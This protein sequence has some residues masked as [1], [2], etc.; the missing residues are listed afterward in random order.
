MPEETV[1]PLKVGTEIPPVPAPPIV[2]PATTLDL[3]EGNLM[4][5][6][7]A[8]EMRTA[9]VGLEGEKQTLLSQVQTLTEAATKR[10]ADLATA[11]QG[12]ISAEASV[13]TAD[14]KTKEAEGKA[15]NFVAPA[16]YQ[17]LKTKLGTQDWNM[18][19][20]RTGRMATQ[21]GIAPDK[22]HGKSVA[23]LDGIEEGLKLS[24]GTIKQSPVLNKGGSGGPAVLDTSNRFNETI[25]KN[26]EVLRRIR[27]GDKTAGEMRR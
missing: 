4:T 7:Q 16:D 17:E 22:L 26:K 2:P 14:A 19:V 6:D 18:L 1:D 20:E 11:N 5:K 25:E 21:Y 15:A 24:G 27:E 3:G 8:I 10:D 9:K 23:E 13:T 12:R